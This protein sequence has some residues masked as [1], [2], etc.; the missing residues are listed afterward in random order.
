M[1]LLFEIMS[2]FRPTENENPNLSS[3]NKQN[4]Q[5]RQ[6]KQDRQ[7]RE[8]ESQTV[9]KLDERTKIV[10]SIESYFDAGNDLHDVNLA[11][12]RENHETSDTESQK[13]QTVT[14]SLSQKKCLFKTKVLV[15]LLFIFLILALVITL[16]FYQRR[17]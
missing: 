1:N 6:N 7:N 13:I 10:P 11:S 16:V 9:I 8:D 17:R 5:D 3:Q 2:S 12:N 14:I 15:C 4:R